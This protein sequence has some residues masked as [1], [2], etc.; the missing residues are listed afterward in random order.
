MLRVTA[1]TNILVSGFNFLAGKPSQF[2][3][4][5]RSGA[6]SLVVSQPIIEETTD[7]LARKFNWTAEDIE[8]ARRW[9]KDIARTVTPAV[10]LDVI[11]EDPPDNRILE[12]AVSAG[13]DYIV[14]GDNDLLRLGQYAGIRIMNVA[15]FLE[16]AR[17]QTRER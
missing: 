12:C 4:L 8:E 16:I 13:S 11:K 10:R 14:T 7:V 17:G 2:L 9:L 5:A 1:D 3:Q 15:D 6:I